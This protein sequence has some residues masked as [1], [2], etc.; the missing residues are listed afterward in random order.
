MTNPKRRP[1]RALKP[2]EVRHWKQLGL[3]EVP[4]SNKVGKLALCARSWVEGLGCFA[5]VKRFLALGRPAKDVRR[6]IAEEKKEPLHF[7]VLTANKYLNL[8]RDF[9]I[10][11]LDM[12][13]A[14]NGGD[15]GVI[16]ERTSFAEKLRGI[17]RTVP[18]IE[19]LEELATMQLERVRESRK[20]EK[21]NLGNGIHTP[22]LDREIQ[23]LNKLLTDVAGLKMDL[24]LEEYMRVPQRLDLRAKLQ[25]VEE[26][27]EREKQALLDFGATFMEL[28]D[29]VKKDGVYQ[30]EN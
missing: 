3:V 25:V 1:K 6:F 15:P 10:S 14:K 26:V 19:R 8:Y 23:V 11:P 21:D 27:T 24:G 29:L 30:K 4:P 16:D 20:F 22:V 12:L 17:K 18:E 7:T 2:G 9:F 13:R 5:E 28:V